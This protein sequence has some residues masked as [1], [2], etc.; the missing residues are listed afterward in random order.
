[1]VVILRLEDVLQSELQ[2]APVGCGGQLTEVAVAHVAVWISE[3]RV[4]EEVEGFTAE[5]EL[6][7]LEE[8]KFLEQ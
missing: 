7:V 3:V 6:S 4:I 8:W 5:L 1:M 2:D